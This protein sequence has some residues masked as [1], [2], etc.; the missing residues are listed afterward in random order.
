MDCSG[1]FQWQSFLPP[2]NFEAIATFNTALP[3]TT[4]LKQPPPHPHLP[5][6][7]QRQSNTAAHQIPPHPVARMPLVHI[8]I[9]P[10]YMSFSFIYPLVRQPLRASG[11]DRYSHCTDVHGAVAIYVPAT[12]NRRHQ[13]RFLEEVVTG[14]F[15]D[16]QGEERVTVRVRGRGRVQLKGVAVQGVMIFEQI[17]RSGAR[18]VGGRLWTAPR[19]Q[20]LHRSCLGILW[21]SVG[22]RMQST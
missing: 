14:D 1:R 2:P 20:H 16:G 5:R 19:R 9:G 8:L 22:P 13:V 17:R 11:V 3:S 12:E 18:K 21:H 6:Q 15:D 10:V 7:K 4:A